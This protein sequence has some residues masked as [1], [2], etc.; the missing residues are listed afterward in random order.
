[1]SDNI[2][3]LIKSNVAKMFTREHVD[4]HYMKGM[5]DMT[6]EKLTERQASLAILSSLVTSTSEPSIAENTN[7]YKAGNGII[8]NLEGA[9]ADNAGCDAIQFNVFRKLGEQGGLKVTIS[10]FNNPVNEDEEEA[11]TILERVDGVDFFQWLAGFEP[12]LQSMLSS[13]APLE[14]GAPESVEEYVEDEGEELSEELLSED[15]HDEVKEEI[16][17]T[18]ER[19]EQTDADAEVGLTALRGSLA[20]LAS[21]YA[22]GYVP[23]V[24]VPE[25]KDLRPMDEHDIAAANLLG[26]SYDESA[27]EGSDQDEEELALWESGEGVIDDSVFNGD[28]EERDDENSESIPSY[29]SVVDE[30]EDDLKAE[31]WEEKHAEELENVLAVEDPE[32][33]LPDL[34]DL[35][36][37]LHEVGE[38]DYFEAGLE[39]ENDHV[40]HLDE[41]DEGAV[42]SP[43]NDRIETNVELTDSGDIDVIVVDDE[44]NVVDSETEEGGSS[45]ESEAESDVLNDDAHFEQPKPHRSDS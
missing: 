44:G 15:E 4:T 21:D 33:E 14:Q 24:V 42:I 35:H 19:I 8:L 16:E 23:S 26:E 28:H 27:F 17:E 43:A 20:Q 36:T 38:D 9:V 5:Y 2:D 34:G 6:T 7:I 13:V 10:S 18:L 25:D 12:Q 39:A 22:N 31:E 41:E 37:N 32:N 40:I 11:H 30:D 3:I 29:L 1:M 45:D